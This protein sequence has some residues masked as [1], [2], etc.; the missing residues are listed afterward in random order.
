MKYLVIYEQFG[1]GCDHT[2]GCGIK[3]EI[4]DS[5]KMWWSNLLPHVEA[6]VADLSHPT[7]T[8]KSASVYKFEHGPVWSADVALIRA[9]ALAM[10][11]ANM[12]DET[13]ERVE[14]ERLRKK[15]GGGSE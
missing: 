1:E 13:R 8:I 12:A 5:S 6:T 14:Y 11:D 7:Q 2:I 4:F 9:K 10:R 3:V 15:Y